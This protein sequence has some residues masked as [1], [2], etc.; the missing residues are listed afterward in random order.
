M[1]PE[2]KRY[3]LSLVLI[4]IL[5]FVVYG[6][7]L[8]GQ[9]IRD[10]SPLVKDNTYI[11]SWSNISKIFTKN[12]AAG[13]GEKWNSYRPLQVIT[14]MMD[15]SLWK[16]NPKGYHLTNILFHIFAALSIYW[17]INI[18]YSQEP[19]ALFTGILFVVH[20]VHTE[21]VTYISGRADSLAAVFMVLCFIF[22]IKNLH[23]ESIGRYNLILI[24]YIFALLSRESSLI[25]PALLLLYHYVFKERLKAK[26]FLS[27]LTITCIYILLRLTLLRSL[28]F[29]IS[30]PTTILQRIPGF[31]IAVTN[32]IRIML[33]PFN[34][35]TGYGDKLFSL[36]DP[37]AMLG[38]LILFSLLVYAF[39]K[40]SS[41]SLIFFS[42]FWFFI[43]LLPQSNIY[44]INAYMAEHWLYLPSVGFFLL[45]A[46]GLSCLYRQKKSRIFAI[47][48][49]IS[50]LA[51]YSCLTIRQNSYWKEP[52][53][54]YERTLKY[55]PDNA[56]VL[57]NLGV[58]YRNLGRSE[59]A[60][61]LYK[62]AI[63][64]NPTD[65]EAYN[66]LAVIYQ[67]LGRNEQAISLYKEAI[68][69]NPDFAKAYYNLGNA[70]K[71]LGR[72]EEIIPLYKKAIKANPEYADAY[73][74]LGNVY[75]NLGKK[76]QAIALIKKAIAVNP[77]YAIAYQNLAII[78]FQQKQYQLAIEN[79]DRAQELGYN[80]PA[81]LK[82]LEPYRKK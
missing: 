14:Y 6:N 29:N 81:F 45:L 2:Q 12:I 53:A 51:F 9:F 31:F 22:Y 49:E 67:G 5:G 54:F 60:I 64:L 56:E 48:F 74:N 4:T 28:L 24:S 68:R 26:Q 40:R 38:I 72:N 59:E 35:H 55:T 36:S 75:Y 8:N 34:L 42:A 37:R 18:L 39:R 47:F 10:D 46:K 50:L 70:Y 77:D 65:A 44:P 19:L 69:I 61:T 66:N 73:N 80:N 63:A 71:D 57:T 79:F 21:A 11:K 30:Y 32:Y 16:L 58:V 15:Y 82:A 43:A 27:I 41:N 62:K 1:K 7:S 17:L 13:G 33:L 3:I 23:S 76:E 20:P 25:L 52:V 78:Y